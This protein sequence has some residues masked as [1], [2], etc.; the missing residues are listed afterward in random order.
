MRSSKSSSKSRERTDSGIALVSIALEIHTDNKILAYIIREDR[1]SRF[2]VLS[3][4][5]ESGL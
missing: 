3:L 2:R 1:S 5:P 4:S